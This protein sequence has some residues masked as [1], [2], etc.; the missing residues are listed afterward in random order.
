M[1]RS[2]L[3]PLPRKGEILRLVSSC[4]EPGA[5]LAIELAAFSGLKPGQVRGLTLRNIVELSLQ[6]LQFSRV[7]ARIELRSGLRRRWTAGFG[8]WYTFLSTSGCE[9]LLEELRGRTSQLSATSLAVTGQAFKEANRMLQVAEVRWFELR[10]YFHACLDVPTTTHIPYQAV[11]FMLGYVVKEDHLTQVRAFFEPQNVEWL[12]GR[13]VQV[14]K[15]FF[16]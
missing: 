16:V 12:R 7:P 4:E 13:Y 10:H 9:S 5:R 2:Y 14:E 3:K 1:P 15:E 8:R 6:S 11:S